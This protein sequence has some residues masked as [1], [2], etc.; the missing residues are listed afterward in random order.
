MKT[1][2]LILIILLARSGFAQDFFPLSINNK[3]QYLE[4]FFRQFYPSPPTII[5][6]YPKVY[7]TQDTVIN[8]ITLHEFDGYYYYYNHSNQNLYILL[9]DSL[10]LAVDFNLPEDSVKIM[11]FNNVERLWVSDGQY[12]DDFLGEQKLHFKM[13]YTYVHITPVYEI[14]ISREFVFVEDIGLTL[15]YYYKYEYQ[16]LSESYYIRDKGFYSGIIDLVIYNPQI[17]ELTVL[18]QLEDRPLNNFPFQLRVGLNISNIQLLDTL[19]ADVYVYR[20]DTILITHN[21]YPIN[22]VTFQTSVDLDSTILQVNDLIKIR[23]VATDNTIFENIAVDPDS[24]YYEFYV[25]SPI[26][27][28]IS[29]NPLNNNFRLEQNYPNPYNPS[30]SI[31]YAVSSMQYVTLKVYDILGNEVA[32]LVDEELPAGVYEVEFNSRGLTRLP[33]GQVHQTLPSGIYFYQLRAGSFIET[34]KML[35]LK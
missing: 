13:H 9:E 26:I 14:H 33:D 34:K 30:T 32:T 20:Q 4:E 6:S 29:V 24:G 12:Y 31:Q 25:L 21:T 15:D 35:M 3:Y 19:Y 5:I 17:L 23:C 18:T 8:Q 1:I 10:K 2:L 11:S 28:D 7:V 16:S 22:K 27:N